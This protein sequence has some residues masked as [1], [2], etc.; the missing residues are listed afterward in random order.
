MFAVQRRHQ[1]RG[2]LMNSEFY[3]GWLD[4]WAQEHSSVSTEAVATALDRIL[5][6]NASVTMYMFHGGTSFGYKAGANVDMVNGFQPTP[7]SY[8]YDAP[9][10]EAGDPTDKFHAIRDVIAKYLPVPHVPVPEPAKK[11]ALGRLPLT[12][13]STEAMQHHQRCEGASGA[14]Q[15]PSELP[16]SFERIRQSQALVLYETWVTFLPRDPAVLSARGLRDRGYVYVDDVYQGI[17]SRMDNV[18]SVMIP[19]TK[20]QRLTILVESQ[21]RVGFVDL[22]DPKGLGRNVTLSGITLTDWNITAINEKDH[23]T[24][25]RRIDDG[26]KSWTPVNQ[27]VPSCDVSPPGLAVYQATFRFD[28][29]PPLDTYLR[30]D[31]W[32]KGTVLL[33]GFNLGRYWTPMGPQRALYVPAVLFR[34]ENLL[35]IIE[36]EQAPC[37]Q[38]SSD[39]YVEFVDEPDING[40]VPLSKL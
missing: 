22:N 19:V 37:G 36:L 8:D 3:T 34:E 32:K 40:P 35:D 23:L 11:M 29:S 21:G 5:S 14:L 30:L 28:V 1:E 31:H 27:S 38:E 18:Y 10:T 17:I 9:M 4:H 16:L 12:K 15:I 2:P 20:G 24:A 33:N 13:V 25:R 6:M 7:T 26:V 39:C